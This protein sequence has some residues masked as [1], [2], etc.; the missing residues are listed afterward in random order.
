MFTNHF[1]NL[2][3]S[4]NKDRIKMQQEI[5]NKNNNIT[6]LENKLLDLNMS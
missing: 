6:E 2:K 1:E 3:L 5:D 4:F